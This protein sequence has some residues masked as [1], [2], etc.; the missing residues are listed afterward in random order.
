MFSLSKPDVTWTILWQRRGS[1]KLNF[2]VP[3]I[4]LYLMNRSGLK[5]CNPAGQTESGATAATALSLIHPTPFPYI[6]TGH[7]RGVAGKAAVINLVSGKTNIS[8]S[9]H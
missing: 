5:L 9:Q 8:F 2:I 4:I 7:E 1:P 3:K 6:T